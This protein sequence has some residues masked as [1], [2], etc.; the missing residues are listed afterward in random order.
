MKTRIHKHKHKPKRQSRRHKGGTDEFERTQL[1]QSADQTKMSNLQVKIMDIIKNDYKNLGKAE[2]DPN[3]NNNA[4]LK[5]KIMDFWQQ[6]YKDQNEDSRGKILENTKNDIRIVIDFLSDRVKIRKKL[7]K[8]FPNNH[9]QDNN[10]YKKSYHELNRKNAIK[11]LH[12]LNA[13]N[14][15]YDFHVQSM[16]EDF[17]PNLEN[18]QGYTPQKK[19]IDTTTELTTTFHPFPKT[20]EEIPVVETPAQR[21]IREKKWRSNLVYGNKETRMKKTA[22]NGS[23]MASDALGIETIF[24]FLRYTG[25]N[26][27]YLDMLEPKEEKDKDTIKDIQKDKFTLEEKRDRMIMVPKGKG[28]E[29]GKEGEVA[30][31]AVFREGL[32]KKYPNAFQEVKEETI[33]NAGYQEVFKDNQYNNFTKGNDLENFELMGSPGNGRCLYHSILRASKY[34][35]IEP[36]S[37]ILGDKEKSDN[38][39]VEFLKNQLTDY[40]VNGLLNDKTNENYEN[41]KNFIFSGENVFDSLSVDGEKVIAR[42]CEKDAWGTHTEVLIAAARYDITI[43]IYITNPGEF[44]RDPPK[45]DKGTIYLI[46]NGYHYDW[47]KP[48]KPIK[49][50]NTDDNSVVSSITANSSYYPSTKVSGDHKRHI[51]SDPGRKGR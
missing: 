50:I 6:V 17:V 31:I 25:A 3:P 43:Q 49:P 7:T 29:K 51:S 15:D 27:D 21:E 14:V 30:S 39:H 18:K 20:P 33:K 32:M 24:N 9:Y 35:G 34:A 11:Y 13:D 38:E 4:E 40:L 42:L 8:K 45:G 28:K 1:K 41:L 47:L 12:K 46:Y 37:T 2:G 19:I 26:F 22:T 23:L 44:I 36:G 5:I 10:T 16:I 48:I